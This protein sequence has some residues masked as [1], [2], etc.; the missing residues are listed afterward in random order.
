MSRLTRRTFLSSTAAGVAAATTLRSSTASAGVQGANDRVRVAVIGTGRQGLS[1]MRNHIALNDVEIAAV[2]DVYGTNLARRAALAPKAAQVQGLPRGA[3]QQGHRRGDH[4]HARSLARADDGDGLPGRQGRLR[5]EADVGRHRRRT[6]DGRGRAQVQPRRA[7]RHAAAFRR[8]TSSRRPRLVQDGGIGKVTA[9]R[10]WNC[11]Q[12]VSRRH[13]QP[14]RQRAAVRPRLGPVA[15]PGAQARRS[16]RT[17]SAWCPTSFSHFRWFWDY[18]GGMMTDWGVHLIDIVQMAMNVD[19]PHVG[20][21]G[22]RQVLP[23]RQPRDAGHDSGELPVPRLRD[24][25]REPHDERARAQRPRLR[26]RVLRHR[27]HAVRRSRRLRTDA[28]D[29][30]RTATRWSAR[31]LGRR[32]ASAR[33]TTRPTRATS[34]TA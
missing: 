2:C 6:Q 17:A 25:L 22:G 16:T 24:D 27:R 30:A 19:A 4:R 28:G 5:R 26:H 23:Q 31:T 18:A 15:R 1:D 10:C 8:R 34:S 32:Q 29:A 11:R 9:V 14:A 13:R 33:R 7:G 20:V 12:P 3:R 21:G